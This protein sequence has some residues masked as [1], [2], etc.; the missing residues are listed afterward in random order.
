MPFSAGLIEEIEKLKPELRGVFIELLKEIERDREE[1]ITRKEGNLWNI[2]QKK[3]LPGKNFL[4]LRIVLRRTFRGYGN[5]LRRLLRHS[6]ELSRGW[7]RLLRAN[8]AEDW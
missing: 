3:A 1:S 2:S 5:L 6:S 7:R 4:S 8:R